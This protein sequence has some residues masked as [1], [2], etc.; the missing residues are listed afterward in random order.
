MT[1]VYGV[2]NDTVVI[3]DENERKEI[4]CYDS[5]AKIRFGDGTMIVIRYGD[6]Q[7]WKIVVVIEGFAFYRLLQCQNEFDEVY[8]DVFEIGSEYVTHEMIDRD[9]QP[10]DVLKRC[11]FCGGK[12]V[13]WKTNYHAWIQCENFRTQSSDAH[14]VQ[15]SADNV[16]EVMEKWNRRCQFE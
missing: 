16:P 14:I 3:E 11:P 13:M 7:I 6:N 2:S 4:G 9:V 15:V 10:V 5:A 1:K 12:A 8:S